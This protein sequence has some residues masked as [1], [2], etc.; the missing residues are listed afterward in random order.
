MQPPRSPRLSPWS[1]GAPR[2]GRRPP[3]TQ[4]LILPPVG[5]SRTGSL[6]HPLLPD[7]SPQ[8]PEIQAPSPKLATEMWRATRAALQSEIKLLRD[9]YGWVLGGSKGW[10]TPDGTVTNS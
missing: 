3:L 5:P 9:L 1:W 10:G 4:T 7:L 6:I 2:V 8:F